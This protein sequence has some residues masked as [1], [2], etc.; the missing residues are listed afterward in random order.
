MAKVDVQVVGL[1]KAMRDIAEYSE[2]AQDRIV[3]EINTTKQ[4]VRN[5]AIKNAP[6]NKQSG[7]G[8]GARGGSLRRMIVAEP[9]RNYEAYVV[10]KA[11][12]SEFVEFGTGIYGE[13]P[14]GGHRT[15]PWVYY[16]EATE[17]FVI[18]RGNKA[19]PFMVPAAEA[20]REDHR[21]RI[22]AALQ[23]KQ[24]PSGGSGTPSGGSG[25]PS[26]ESKVWVNTGSSIFHE[27][28]S[29]HFSGTQKGEYMTRSEALSRGFR[30]S[31]R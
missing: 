4:L 12:Y 16:N 26:G 9:T 29:K 21:R 31:Q 3:Q 1:E 30:A 5:D 2:Q 22:I 28:G 25:T 8:M 15:T 11:H 6:V 19:Q 14:K 7:S 10:S 13:N 23:G 20:N 18:T 17:S 27:Q 24:S